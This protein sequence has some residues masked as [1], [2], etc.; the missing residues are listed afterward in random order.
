MTQLTPVSVRSNHKGYLAGMHARIVQEA[1]FN[2]NKPL[3][4][5]TPNVFREYEYGQSYCRGWRDMH[6]EIGNGRA[7]YTQAE[8]HT[9]RRVAW[10]DGWYVMQDSTQEDAA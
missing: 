7:H 10:G 8:L 6:E 3:R 4:C 1:R 2:L 9:K 5:P